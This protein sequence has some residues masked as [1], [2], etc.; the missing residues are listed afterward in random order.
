MSSTRISSLILLCLCLFAACAHAQSCADALRRASGSQ[1][2]QSVSAQNLQIPAKAWQHLEKARAASESNQPQVFARETE[3]ALAIA[4]QFAEIYLLRAAQQLRLGQNEAA[5]ENVAAARRIEPD[6]PWSHVIEA[7]ALTQFRRYDEA[8]AELDRARGEE[9]ASWQA[10]FE[11]ARAET[12]RHD[13]AA[14]LHWSELAVEAAPV[15]C[16]DVLLVRANA[17]QIAG[18][19]PEAIHQLELYLELDRRGVNDPQVLAALESAKATQDTKVAR[20]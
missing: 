5:L 4:P 16:T 10:S 20:K 6:L 8:V 9:A 2:T 14:A 19:I 17:F 13:S 12:G 7:G 3:R 18:R 11:R 1:F 15:G